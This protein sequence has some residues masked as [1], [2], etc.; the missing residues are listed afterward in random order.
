MI[1]PTDILYREFY[2][3][4]RLFIVVVAGNPYLFDGSFSEELDEYPD[5]FE[6]YR[7]PPMSHADLR[8]SWAGLPARAVAHLGRVPTGGVE[9]DSTRRKRID[10]EVLRRL[11]A[12]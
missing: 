7:L 1:E 4:P 2:D 5:H 6:V 3:F 9:F 8:G 11:N 12:G 10:A